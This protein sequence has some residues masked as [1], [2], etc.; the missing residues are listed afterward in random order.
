MP[1]TV[2]KGAPEET[3]SRRLSSGPVFPQEKKVSR[4]ANQMKGWG[5][6]ISLASSVNFRNPI[7]CAFKSG[8]KRGTS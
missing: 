8:Q 3:V 5:V 1:S 6:A 2:T 7:I 4:Q